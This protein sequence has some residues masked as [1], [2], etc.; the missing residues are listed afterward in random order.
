[1]STGNRQSDVDNQ[2]QYNARNQLSVIRNSGITTRLYYD[3]D[4]KLI[5]RTM[6]QGNTVHTIYYL[7]GGYKHYSIIEQHKQLLKQQSVMPLLPF[8][9]CDKETLLVNKDT[10]AY[11][12]TAA[13]QESGSNSTV[14]KQH[15]L[16][17][18]N[19]P[20]AVHSQTGAVL[21]SA[22]IG[23]TTGA[24][25]GGL[26]GEIRGATVGGVS[27]AFGYAIG[28]SFQYSYD[29]P[30]SALNPHA[31]GLRNMRQGLV[32]TIDFVAK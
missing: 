14:I 29:S 32:D 7:A 20:I 18:D 5:E 30:M 21:N 16:Y 10:L 19:L 22:I 8:L 6:T 24:I 27:V 4:G 1:M 28:L 9:Q 15:T 31:T 26:E 12:H 11:K 13:T 3:A 23:G 2:Y 25:Q 17:A